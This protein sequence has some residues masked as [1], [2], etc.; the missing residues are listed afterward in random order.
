MPAPKDPVKRAAWIKKLQNK[1]VTQESRDAMSKAK[2]GIPL[3]KEH[4][5]KISKSNKGRIKSKEECENI[6]KGLKG[7][8]KS[9]EHCKHLSEAGMGREPWNRG[10]PME[11]ATRKKISVSHTGKTTSEETK[12]KQSVAM[13][14]NTHTL[15]VYPS[16]ATKKKMSDSHK[17][18]KSPMWKGGITPL[19]RAVRRLPEY[20]SWIL[21][22][23]QKDNYTCQ[24]CNKHGGDLN[25]H[26]IKKFSRI[27]EEN[28]ITSTEQ[29]LLC[30]ELWDLNNGITFCIKCHKKE[31]KKHLQI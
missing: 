24:R 19:N 16:D 15:G 2:K 26:H 23:F 29:A 18:E 31:H 6:S 27:I 20:N 3:T 7:K 10:I 4:A 8:P 28:L 30:R 14:G 1:V 17:G 13:M 12:E 21:S 25:A 9:E 22:V 11:D 5:E